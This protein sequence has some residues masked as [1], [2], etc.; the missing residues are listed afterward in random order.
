LSRNVGNT[1]VIT[2]KNAVL[3][4]FTA[5]AWNK[6]RP[7]LFIALVVG[8]ME[9]FCICLRCCS[10]GI[11]SLSLSCHCHCHCRCYCHC[12]CHVTHCHCHY[13]LCGLLRERRFPYERRWLACLSLPPLLQQSSWSQLPRTTKWLHNFNF[14]ALYLWSYQTDTRL[15]RLYQE[16]YAFWA[17]I[18]AQA[19]FYLQYNLLYIIL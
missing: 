19:R 10:N 17:K 13:H 8:I 5:N 11:L 7:S 16:Y 1:N 6:G 2:Q 15:S 9:D 3:I 4:Y 12:Y 18:W 14:N